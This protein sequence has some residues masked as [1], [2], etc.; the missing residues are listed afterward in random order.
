[1]FWKNEN[2]GVSSERRRFLPVPVHVPTVSGRGSGI[3]SQLTAREANL[4]EAHA[5]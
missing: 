3:H 1:M 4:D 2:Q 5:L